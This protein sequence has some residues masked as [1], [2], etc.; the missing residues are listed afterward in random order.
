VC[1][2]AGHNFTTASPTKTD[3]PIDVSFGYGFWPKEPC[4][5]FSHEGTHFNMHTVMEVSN[6]QAYS[7][8]SQYGTQDRRVAAITV[9]RVW[10]CLC[11]NIASM[12]SAI[13]WFKYPHL[14]CTRKL[15]ATSTIY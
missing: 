4:I 15:Y 6:Q 10:I 1:V 14:A 5:R 12:A 13:S 2:S 7:R 8:H 11:G 3:Q 9:Y